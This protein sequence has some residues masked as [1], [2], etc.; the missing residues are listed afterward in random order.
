MLTTNQIAAI[1][2]TSV[3]RVQDRLR[4]LRE[5]GVV[6]AF[7]E[8]YVHGGTSQTRFALGYL[9]ARLI[10]AQRAAKPRFLAVSSGFARVMG[11]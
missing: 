7:R 3:R 1:E 5:L 11:G 10:A 8:S 2:F 4:R 6:F 9:G